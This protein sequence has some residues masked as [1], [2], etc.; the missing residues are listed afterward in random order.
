MQLYLGIT[1]YDSM[2]CENISQYQLGY[3][4]LN[5]SAVVTEA[6][7]HKIYA[8]IDYGPSCKSNDLTYSPAI[9]VVGALWIDRP[10]ESKL[11]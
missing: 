1:G 11:H 9:I 6:G 8:F 2:T 7:C 10:S 3:Q 5:Y 4:R